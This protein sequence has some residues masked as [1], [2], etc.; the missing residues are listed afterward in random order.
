MWIGVNF[1]ETSKD[2]IL[3]I[4]LYNPVRDVF[5][6]Q[7][8]T[9]RSEVKDCDITAIKDDELVVVE[10]KRNLSVSLLAQAARRQK[11]ADLVYIAVPKPKKTF[12]DSKW[13]DICHL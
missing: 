10:L 13:Q 1:V 7:G 3:E 11:A 5:V 4:D 8:Y 2:K 12:N 9:V 6:E